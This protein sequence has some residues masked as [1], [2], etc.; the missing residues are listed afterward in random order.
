MKT[1]IIDLSSGSHATREEDESL[2]ALFVGGRG[3]TTKIFSDMAPQGVGPLSPECPILFGTGPLTGTPFP[4]AG[5]FEAT[6]KSP[7]TGTIFTASCGGRLGVNLRKAGYDT[8]IVTGSAAGPSY[9]FIDNDRVS[10]LDAS[11]LWGRTKDEVKRALRARHGAETSILLIGRAGEECIPYANIE[12]DGRFL[13][14]GGLGAVL[15][16]KRVKA[17]AVRGHGKVP[18]ADR[19]TFLFLSYECRKW[20]AANPITSKGLRDFGTGILLNYMREVGLLPAKNFREPA[21]PESSQISGEMIS[22]RLLKRRKACFYC[23]VACGRLT[24]YGEGPE[25]ETLWALGV[26]LGIHD[27]EGVARLNR[28]CNELGLDTITTGGVIGLAQELAEMDDRPLPAPYGDYRAVET[29]I[30]EMVKGEGSGKE[31]RP[32]S[33]ELGRRYGRQGLAAQVKGLELPAYDPR[34]A[35]GHALGYATSNRG[36]CHMQGYLVGAEILGVPKMVPPLSVDGKASL[37]ALYQNVSAFVDSLVM[38]RFASYAVPHDYYARV[39]SAATGRGMSWEESLLTGERIW[40]LERM[41]NLREEVEKDM[42]PP[43]FSQVPLDRLL[44]EYYA[45]R[46]WDPAGRPLP[47]TL[48]RLSLL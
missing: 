7:L 16:A 47:E 44:A 41:V 18:L 31:L 23:P 17:I 9:V 15:G 24:T 22:S 4:M 43:R 8:L 19:E 48:N 45:I 33:R 37:L 3:V 42:L 30:E 6:T 2:A 36:G 46:G 5:R 11:S 25:Y 20:L 27:V 13:G 32:G 1:L 39:A 10:C 34:G 28:L 38:C 21:P 12:N 14:R 26:N 35:Y 40:N 29:L